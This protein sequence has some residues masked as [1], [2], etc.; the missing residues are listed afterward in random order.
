MGA[1]VYLDTGVAFETPEREAWLDHA[2][3]VNRDPAEFFPEKGK[4]ASKTAEAKKICNNICSVRLKCLARALADEM[5]TSRR[6][7]VSG[8][9]TPTERG[10]LQ[11]R[12]D[13]MKEEEHGKAG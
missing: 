11:K 2:A 3:C 13:K 4:V 10:E 9:L 8:G 1:R 7:G 5:E 12:L 6:Y